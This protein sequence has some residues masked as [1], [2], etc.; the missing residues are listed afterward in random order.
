MREYTDGL[1]EE[2]LVLSV[3]EHYRPPLIRRGRIRMSCRMD[4]SPCSPSEKFSPGGCFTPSTSG[5]LIL[6]GVRVFV[7]VLPDLLGGYGEIG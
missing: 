3:V 6:M 5:S 2:A 7:L 4:I 1:C